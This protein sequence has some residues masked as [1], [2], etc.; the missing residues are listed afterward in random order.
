MFPYFM[1]KKV[2]IFLCS[3]SGSE[4]QMKKIIIDDYLT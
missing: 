3:I 4:R 1:G 2:V